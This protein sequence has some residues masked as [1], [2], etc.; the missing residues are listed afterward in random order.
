MNRR[1]IQILIPITFLLYAWPFSAWVSD[2]QEP[3]PTFAEHDVLPAV[4]GERPFIKAE[5]ITPASGR[6]MVHAAAMGELP[7][8]RLATVWYGGSREG[9]KD[10]AIFWAERGSKPTDHW[11]PPR[12]L[13]NRSSATKELDRYIKKVGN[14]I[15]FTGPDE[16]IWLIYVSVTVGGWSGSSINLK[17]SQDGGLNWQPSRRLTL[18]PLFNISELVRNKPVALTRGQVAIPLYHECLGKFPELLWIESGNG[19]SSLSY[20]KTR[21]AGGTDFI[22]PCVVPYAPRLAD[23]FYRCTG[24]EKAVGKASTTTA[25]AS[26]SPPQMLALPNPDAGLDAVLLSGARILMA[27]NDTPSGRDNLRL[28]ISDDHGSTWQRIATL[29][30]TPGEEF[31]YPY[32]ISTQTGRIHLVYTWRRKRI[33]HVVFNEA[34]VNMQAKSAAK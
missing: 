23:A 14:P 24:R 19:R 34:W 30:N 26:W 8:G 27:F 18:S 17:I 10:V 33:K 32:L 31:S 25:G 6:N 28:A 15:M 29:E 4:K 16:R 2:R 12:V 3:A 13:V 21:M 7:D 9:A 1:F 5:F 22:Q 20:R 11:S